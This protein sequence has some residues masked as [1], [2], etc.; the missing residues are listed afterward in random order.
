MLFI[1]GVL[2]LGGTSCTT[3]IMGHFYFNIYFLLNPLYTHLPSLILLYLPSPF[4]GG[5]GVVWIVVC[6]VQ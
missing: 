1:S 3:I 5:F 6:V 4:V 2:L